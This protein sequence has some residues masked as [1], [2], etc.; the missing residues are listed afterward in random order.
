AATL[1]YQCNAG[2]TDEGDNVATDID[3]VLGGSGDD[4]LTGDS[5]ANTLNGNGGNDRLDGG[6]GADTLVGGDGRDLAD[7][8]SR[9]G[10]LMVDLDNNSD[11]G[12]GG[13][14]DN[15]RS[16]VEDVAGGSG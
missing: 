4:T 16:D 12:E 6:R 10:N 3:R 1:D 5:Y 13:E 15:V 9:G 8:S 2:E 11:D 14:H 7:Y